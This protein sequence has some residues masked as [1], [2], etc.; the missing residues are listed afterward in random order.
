[1]SL[2]LCLIVKNEENNI[3][4][5]LDSAYRWVDEIVIADTGSEDLTR[6]S[7]LSFG[8]RVFDFEW[9]DDFS[10]ARNYILEKASGDWIL[11]LDADEELSSDDFALIKEC[12]N[13]TEANS[14]LIKT[15]HLM[16]KAPHS[17][18]RAFR[19]FEPRLFR[20]GA[21][22]KYLGKIRESLCDSDKQPVNKCV[23]VLENVLIKHHG[24]TFESR[25]AK[26]G[27][28]ISLLQNELKRDENDGFTLYNLAFE[29]FAM[30]EYEK[31]LSLLLRSAECF[32]LQYQ[33]PPAN[34]YK[35]KF[36]AMLNLG[37]ISR[38]YGLA[39]KA[40]RLYPD[41]VDLHFYKAL[42]LYANGRYKEA[43]EGFAYCL[44]LGEGHKDYITS[45]GYGVCMALYL[46]GLSYE[47]SGDAKHSEE[48]FS[49]AAS[50][51]PDPDALKEEVNKLPGIKI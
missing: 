26:G 4:R 5:C 36:E 16:G 40:I 50:V 32:I 3:K 11:F 30:G 29:Y 19:T 44:L 51:C 12:L 31:A 48:L 35:L 47:K 2:S 39:E 8:A 42:S 20:R 33:K 25:K 49:Q 14:F 6:E 18:I 23:K 34:L 1:M 21:G 46:L 41:Y 45:C 9:K 43:A 27:R 24:Y 17:P 7:C 37:E 13:G 38:V 10:L 22:F 28:N 15:I